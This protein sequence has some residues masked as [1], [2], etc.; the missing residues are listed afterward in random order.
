MENFVFITGGSGHIG[1]R[2]IVDAL[3]AG[4]SVRAAVRNK[5]KAVRICA[6][7]SVHALNP[8]KKLEFVIVP[9]FSVDGAYEDVVKGARYVIHIASP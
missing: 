9:D 5:S 8:G 7:P 2:V 4:Y 1:S 6:M 3:E